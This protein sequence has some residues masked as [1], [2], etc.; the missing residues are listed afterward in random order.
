MTE[1]IIEAMIESFQGRG[2]YGAKRR[3]E[4]RLRALGIG[5]CRSFGSVAPLAKLVTCGV[6]ASGADIRFGMWTD[7][8]LD[9]WLAQS[10][11]KT[12]QVEGTIGD[13]LIGGRSSSS[14]MSGPR[15]SGSACI[16]ID[17][18]TDIQ[19]EWKES[20]RRHYSVLQ[21]MAPWSTAPLRECGQGEAYKRIFWLVFLTWL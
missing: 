13:V 3:G 2:R 8:I 7:G 11:E 10:K 16:I 4:G 9:G 21:S 12:A 19:I 6:W 15:A 5:S 18:A 14:G 17:Y 20:F 1:A